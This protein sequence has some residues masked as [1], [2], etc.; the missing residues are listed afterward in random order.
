[1]EKESIPVTI[2][3]SGSQQNRILITLY[4]STNKQL[5]SAYDHPPLPQL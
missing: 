1:M 4:A 3:D 5:M 2:N